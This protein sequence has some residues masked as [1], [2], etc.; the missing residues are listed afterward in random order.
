MGR[1]HDHEFLVAGYAILGVSS[2]RHSTE[3]SG[4]AGG[5]IRTACMH[6]CMHGRERVVF[7]GLDPREEYGSLRAVRADVL[8]FRASVDTLGHI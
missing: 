5:Q 1:C 7:L 4:R 8:Y 2:G 3:T 6:A